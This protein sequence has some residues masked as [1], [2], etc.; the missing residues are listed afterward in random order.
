MKP[1]VSIII[2][3][4]NCRHY[5]NECLNSL[6][7]QQYQNFQAIIIDDC[8]TDGT[9]ELL[10]GRLLDKRFGYHRQESNSGASIARNKG[11]EMAE[12]E[13]IV[14]LDAD[15]LLLPSHLST[16]VELLDKMPDIGLVCCDSRLI[17]PE[18]E[19]LH[20][21]QTW[22][23][24]QCVIKN[25]T[26]RTGPRSL[27]DIFQFSLCFTGFTVRRDVYQELGGLDQSIFPLDDYDF[28]LRLA[29][30]GIGVFYLNEVHALRRDHATNWSGP[31]YAV[32][33]AQK[34]LECLEH[35]LM[36]N[37]TL[38]VD[39]DVWHSRF[40]EA[41]EE[42]AI[43]HYYQRQYLPALIATARATVYDSER[44]SHMARLLWRKA[45]R[46]LRYM[47]Q[48]NQPNHA[49]VD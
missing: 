44:L 6:V 23:E 9:A 4:Y 11:V 21:G 2:P 35:A 1:L 34:K 38:H 49:N 22:H 43:S 3:T 46:R 7:T 13:Y 28:M 5:I 25:R 17:G 24:V 26:L 27:S 33:V 39:K 29:G 12:G 31:R 16:T 8:S 36:A 48:A 20:N 47:E 45:R 10:D 41:Y 15:D 30:R 40:G 42:L 32:K 14:L 19:I 37:P 18:G